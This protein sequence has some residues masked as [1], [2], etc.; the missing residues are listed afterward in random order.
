MQS[1]LAAPLAVFFEFQTVFQ[2]LF[3]LARKIIHAVA[4]RALKLNK[5]IL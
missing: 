4:I 2:R 1:M 5:I 3:V